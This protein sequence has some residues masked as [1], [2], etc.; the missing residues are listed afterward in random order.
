MPSLNREWTFFVLGTSIFMS[1]LVVPDDAMAQNRAPRVISACVRCHGYDGIGRESEIPNIAGQSAFY[2]RIQMNAF[3][4]GLRHH[5]DMRYISRDL[6]DWEVD[7]LITY[8]S[9]LS[10]R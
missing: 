2:L 1:A 4:I 3:K 8:Y 9:S 10:T 7:E 5:P 6:S